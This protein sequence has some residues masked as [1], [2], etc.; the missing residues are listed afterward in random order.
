[1]PR[2]IQ[3]EPSVGQLERLR[4]FLD[5]DLGE[6]DPRDGPRPEVLVAMTE[7]FV[8][9][10]KHAKIDP[11]R[12]ILVSSQRLEG[13]LIVT[14]EY[15]GI[16]FRPDGAREP[17]WDELPENGMGL[18]VAWQLL[19]SLEFEPSTQP[20]GTQRIRARKKIES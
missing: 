11:G 14:L 2:S 3:L 18:F 12:T 17:C 19:D 9:A 1:M 6:L 16:Q 15:D 10:C 4:E 20:R 13:E 8:N 5:E 7:L